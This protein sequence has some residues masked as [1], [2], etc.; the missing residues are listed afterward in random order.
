MLTELQRKNLNRD[1]KL[2]NASLV[3]EFSF[4]GFSCNLTILKSCPLLF[5]IVSEIQMVY[6]Q[7]SKFVFFLMLITL[8]CFKKVRFQ[9][10]TPIEMQFRVYV[11]QFRFLFLEMQK[12]FCFCSCLQPFLLFSHYF[13]QFLCQKEKMCIFIFLIVFILWWKHV[14]MHKLLLC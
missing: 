13:W 1:Y 12:F 7:S 2:T 11:S 3:S 14:S 10:Q 4:S 5:A 8:S 9:I 6:L